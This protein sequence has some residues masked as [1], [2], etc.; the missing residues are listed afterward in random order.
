MNMN[1]PIIR[2]EVEGMKHSMR[3]ALMEHASK[4]DK[5]V[6]AAV[7]EYCTPQNI[8]SVVRQA[9]TAA[10]DACVR[11]EVRSFFG[12]SGN[13]RIAV[14]EAVQQRLDELYPMHNAKDDEPPAGG[15][16]LAQS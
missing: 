8:D 6:L 7:E 13:G 11:E 5:S 2:L 10:L 1:L 14:R 12:H 15:R 16:G 4:V 9:A 3:V